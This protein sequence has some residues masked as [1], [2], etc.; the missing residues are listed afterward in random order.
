MSLQLKIV[1]YR[2]E[3][4]TLYNDFHIDQRSKDQLIEEDWTARE[5]QSHLAGKSPTG[6]YNLES[7]TEIFEV[8]D[9]SLH[10]V[11]RRDYER[12]YLAKRGWE[13]SQ[14]G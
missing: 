11:T 4:T 5:L 7:L 8:A 9:Y 13:M 6:D 10:D 3:I 1:N 12:F 14:G 2:E